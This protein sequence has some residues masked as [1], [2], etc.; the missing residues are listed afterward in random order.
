MAI[1]GRK[2]SNVGL[3]CLEKGGEPVDERKEVLEVRNTRHERSKQ[4][5]LKLYSAFHALSF[6]HVIP[7]Q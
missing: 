4:P 5:R 6:M 2:M 1:S 7:L 3:G